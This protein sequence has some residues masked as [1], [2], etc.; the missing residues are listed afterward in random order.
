M[1]KKWN[2]YDFQHFINGFKKE[3]PRHIFKQLKAVEDFLDAEDPSRGLVSD[4]MKE[5]CAKFRY[6]FSQFKSVYELAKAGS[7]PSAD[8]ETV[9]VHRASLDIYQQAFYE[10]CDN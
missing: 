1:R 8:V 5:C 7:I 3:N 10:R 4:V 2:C 9:S 6:Q